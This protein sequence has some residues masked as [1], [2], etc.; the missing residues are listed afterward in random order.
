MNGRTWDRCVYNRTCK[1][2]GSKTDTEET[3]SRKGVGRKGRVETREE[4]LEV[5][6]RDHSEEGTS[7]GTRRDEKRPS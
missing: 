4:E 5:P 7:E 6:G 3:E 1:G 2:G